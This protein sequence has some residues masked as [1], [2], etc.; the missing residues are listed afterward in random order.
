MV[1][2]LV[3]LLEERCAS[4]AERIAFT[5][6]RD[7]ETVDATWTYVELRR[8]A[9]AVAVWLQQHLAPGT[10]VLISHASP[11]SW[12]EAFIGC[13]YA[14]VVAVPLP[15]TKRA[16][17]VL[18]LA[19][20]SGASCALLDRAM[21][22]R[23][24]AEADLDRVLVVVVEDIDS[25]TSTWKRPLAQLDSPLLIQY[26]SGSTGTPKGSVITNGTMLANQAMV[27]E[28]FGH[29]EGSV[30]AG[31]LPLFHDMGLMGNV[32]QPLFLGASAVLMPP[33]AF[34]ERP[35]RWLR[36]I[37]TYRAQT[38][39]GPNFAYSMC[40]HAIRDN[41]VA[42]LDLSCWYVAFNGAEPVRA[43][44]MREFCDRFAGIGFSKAAFLPCY[45]LAEA[46]LL[47]AGHRSG[48]GPTIITADIDMLDD[49]FVVRSNDTVRTRDLV[50]CGRPAPGLQVEIRT[51]EGRR[52]AEGELGVIC[53]SGP[54][55]SPGY[56]G[57]AASDGVLHTSDIGA[58]FA[59]ELVVVGRADDVL[60]VHGRKIHPEDVESTVSRVLGVEEH[61]CAAFQIPVEEAE[62]IVV[63]AVEARSSRDAPWRISAL[64]QLRAAVAAEHRIHL[65]RVVFVSRWSLPRTTSG[66]VRRGTCKN[67]FLEGKLRVLET[68]EGLAPLE[69][70]MPSR[71]QW[72]RAEVAKV[73]GAQPQNIDPGLSVVALGLDSVQAARLCHAARENGWTLSLHAV[74]EASSLEVLARRCVAPP[75]IATRL[76]SKSLHRNIPLSRRQAAQWF[77]QQY[78]AGSRAYRLAFAVG[79]RAATCSTD[80]LCSALRS[81]VGRHPMLRYAYQWDGEKPV[82]TLANALPPVNLRDSRGMDHDELERC[83]A[84]DRDESVDLAQ[85]PILRATVFDCGK[86]FII[87]V[88]THHIAVDLW[89]VAVLLREVDSHLQ[90][91][92]PATAAAATALELDFATLESRQISEFDARGGREQ[93]LARIDGA[94]PLELPARAWS[95]AELSSPYEIDT[96][97]F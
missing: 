23:F 72:L 17:G 25:D 21:A 97:G 52:A 44:T 48:S 96:S 60:V 24:A 83:L 53:V 47:V 77:F 85:G 54:S 93:F 15:S 13:A 20:D 27:K 31:W 14:G 39:G 82:A 2:S 36:A 34:L 33:S 86:E 35:S 49:G 89:S 1:S 66:K 43:A 61:S 18:H 50:S 78:A 68:S 40:A 67:A 10:R 56:W 65:W 94:N 79:L 41:E 80:E 70:D 5:F 90:G 46:T 74:L 63:L 76:E 58:F 92:A 6:L 59:G 55:V 16:E 88:V 38:S 22:R 64:A 95:N 42:G 57:Q 12:I 8:R 37:S 28:A 69:A 4:H 81:A 29:D 73:L 11:A 9:C 91:L 51:S 7:G 32:L 87:Q 84:D 19:R 45:G 75:A 26:T 62:P 30:F 71:L 3:D